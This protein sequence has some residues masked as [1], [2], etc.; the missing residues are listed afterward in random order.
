MLA[1]W[2]AVSASQ[3][4]TTLRCQLPL[5]CDAEVSHCQP[6]PLT[7]VVTMDAARGTVTVNKQ[8]VEA[9][10]GHPAKVSFEHRG[11]T[12]DIN[13]YDTHILMYA[14]DVVRMGSCTRADVAW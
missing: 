9:N 3:A 13:R 5:R 6:D 12:V 4:Q 11:H 1:A 2:C 10:H 14:P 7:L 8:L